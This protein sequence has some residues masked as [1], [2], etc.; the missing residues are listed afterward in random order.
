MDLSKVHK[1]PYLT[2]RS[3][4]ARLIALIIVT[5]IVVVAFFY[6]RTASQKQQES[7]DQ[8]E[9]T[10]APPV[11]EVYAKV[12]PARLADV[13]DGNISDRVWISLIAGNDILHTLCILTFFWYC[14]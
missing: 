12:D 5:V 1:N 3:D 9:Y 4:K 13:K 6:F 11:R 14:L 10:Y 8:D 2:P 7:Y